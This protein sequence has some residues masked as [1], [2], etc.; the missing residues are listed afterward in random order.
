LFLVLVFEAVLFGYGI[1]VGGFGYL[2]TGIAVVLAAI[3]F[4]LLM[5]TRPS[6]FR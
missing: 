2:A 4:L 1:Y 5:L 6:R 3:T